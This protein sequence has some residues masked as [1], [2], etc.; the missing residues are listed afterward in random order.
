M[1]RVYEAVRVD[2]LLYETQEKFFTNRITFGTLYQWNLMG[3]AH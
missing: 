2:S 3:W 1:A